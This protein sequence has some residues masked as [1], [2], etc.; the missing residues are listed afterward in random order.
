MDTYNKSAQ[1]SARDVTTTF[2][3]SFSLAS[4]FFDAPTRQHIY[5]I[6]GLVRIADEIVDTYQ[7][8]DMISLLDDL[9]AE[10][11]ATLK[12]NFSS[13]VIIHAFALT[14]NENGINRELIVPFFQSMRTDITKKTYTEKQ[15]KTYIYGSAEVIGLMC[16]KV[17]VDAAEYEK[18]KT[19]AAALGAAFQKVNFLRD[20]RD[21]Y[22]Q[23]G[24]YYFPIASYET[25]DE[26]TKQT[27]IQD[28][29]QDIAVAKEALPHLPSRAKRAVSIA[30]AYYNQLLLELANMSAED[31]KSRR[32]SVATHKKILLTLQE[33]IR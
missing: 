10:V 33:V 3:S 32:M 24:R 7:G 22:L 1:L 5:N 6:Y 2:S 23:R 4:R 13:N 29:K 26:A 18:L 20:M 12:R 15:Y 30:L 11:Y 27:I 28:I 17:F 16:L 25:F 14:A 31:I 9:E 19:G 21:D 8:E